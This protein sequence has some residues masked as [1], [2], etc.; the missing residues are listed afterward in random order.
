MEPEDFL[1]SASDST[2]GRFLVANDGR[3]R[4]FVHMKTE[5]VRASVM[6]NDVEVV[7]APRDIGRI[8]LGDENRVFVEDRAR[9]HLPK[10]ADDRASPSHDD[11][12]GIVALN[13]VV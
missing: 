2:A 5:D 9:Q 4:L 1:N 6:P 13:G 10:R 8:E 12:R 7:L 3:S 11:G